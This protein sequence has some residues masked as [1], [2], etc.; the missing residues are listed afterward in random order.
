MYNFFITNQNLNGDTVKIDDA[1]FNHIKNVLRMKVGDNFLVSLDNKSSLC[2]I[3]SFENDFL[4]AKIIKRDCYD[5]ALP[6]EI[7]L[8]Q[9]LPKSDK[10]ELIIQKAVELGVY[11]IIPVQMER[12]IAK[13]E[14]SKVKSKTERFNAI[15]ESA[16]KQS[17]MPFIPTVKE[18]MSFNSAIDYAKM[19]DVL[20][21][22]YENKDGIESTI[23]ALNKIQKGNKVGIFI[24]PEGGFSQ[25]EVED[26]EK[27]GDLISLGKRI[28]RT[29]TASITAMSMLMLYAEMKLDK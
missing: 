12:S 8:F 13:I 10:L 5:T 26:A 9:G 22:P 14:S 19:L 6:I 4:L 15:A 2:E 24:G 16:A 18:P 3:T 20:L 23:S 21:I 7:Y 1:D 25:K 11:Q 29:E 17:K 28:L 27:F